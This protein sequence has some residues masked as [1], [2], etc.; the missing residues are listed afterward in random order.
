M[1]WFLSWLLERDNRDLFSGNVH[2][3]TLLLEELRTKPVGIGTSGFFHVTYAF[4]AQV[5]NMMM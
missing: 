4:G 5:R 3:L 1:Q 2:E